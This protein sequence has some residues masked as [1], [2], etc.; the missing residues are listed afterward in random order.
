MLTFIH[1]ADWQLGKPFAGIGDAAK[2]ARVQQE[3]IDALRRIRDAVR[4]RQAKFVVVA[5]DLFDSP[6]PT[7][8]TVAQSLGVIGEFGVPVYAIPGNHDHG[9]LDGLWDQPFF[10]QEHANRAPNFQVLLE[11]KPVVLDEA[12]LFP[13]PLLRRHETDDPTAWVR[14]LDFTSYGETPRIV[15]AHGST[16]IFGGQADGEDVGGPVNTIAIERLPLADLDYVA[17]GDW[18]GFTVA[19]PKSWYSGTHETD[20]F[21][22]TDQLPGRVA[23]VTVSRGTRPVVE[24]LVTGRLQWIAHELSMNDDGPSQCEQTLTAA[25]ADAGFDACLVDLSLRGSVSLAARRE[26]DAV[27]E[28]WSHRLLRLDVDDA[29]LLEPSPDEIHDLAN[30]PGDPI[31]SRVAGELARRL[32]GG[33]ADVADV[34]QAINILH[35]LCTASPETQP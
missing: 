15:I 10:K 6:T 12:V 30:R 8:T 29:V 3:R 33:G 32:E 35:S 25:T 16:T 22:K 21:P 26:L 23:C 20:R 17:L 28:S 14:D 27:L 34:R 2:R 1:T 9:G 4:A 18:H 13:C 19:G 11:R 31:I 24:A 5:G 7:K